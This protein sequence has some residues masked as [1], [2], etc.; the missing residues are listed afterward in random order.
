MPEL[1]VVVP[2]RDDLLIERCLRSIDHAEVR[3]LVVLNDP[4]AAVRRLVEDAGAAYIELPTAGGPAACEQGIRAARDDHVLLM[5]SDCVFRP[6]ALAAFQSAVGSAP[7]VRGR[8]VFAHTTRVERVVAGVRTMHTNAPSFVFKVPLMIDRR[9]AP[10]VGGYFF[11][12]RLTWTEDF[13]LTHRVRASGL[14]VRRLSEGVVVHEPLTPIRDLR[15]AWAYGT[16]HRQGTR[17]GL[18]GYNRVGIGRVSELPSLARQV[19]PAMAAYALAFNLT[20]TI[21]YAAEVA[22]ERIAR[23][24]V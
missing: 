2:V 10:L 5:D 3:P 14:A 21:G 22:R 7:F 18:P 19:G 13:D 1:T 17:M 11:D 8:V 4:T 15:S 24:N 23:D 12:Q 9:V 6:G 16:G 20:T